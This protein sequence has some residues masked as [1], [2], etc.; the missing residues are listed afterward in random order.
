MFRCYVGSY[1]E[2]MLP[3]SIGDIVVKSPEVNVIL[4]DLDLTLVNK[5]NTGW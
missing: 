4:S 5:K 1:S 2:C 3:M